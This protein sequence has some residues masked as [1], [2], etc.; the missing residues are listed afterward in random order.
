LNSP[1]QSPSSD[2]PTAVPPHWPLHAD[3][4]YKTLIDY[5]INNAIG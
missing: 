4:S 2:A 5:C 1:W 3:N